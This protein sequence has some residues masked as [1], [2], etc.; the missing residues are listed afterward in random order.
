VQGALTEWLAS[1]LQVWFSAGFSTGERKKR[2]TKKMARR[3]TRVNRKV[4]KGKLKEIT[5]EEKKRD[6]EHKV[7]G[8]ES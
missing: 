7:T 4:N 5:G 6:K 3:E 8:R 1:Q 2:I